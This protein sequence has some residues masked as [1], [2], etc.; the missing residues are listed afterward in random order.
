MRSEGLPRVS[1][2]SAPERELPA[3]AGW[4]FRQ[5]VMRR[6]KGEPIAFGV[7][8][9]TI[10]VCASSVMD[11]SSAR[12]VKQWTSRLGEY[13]QRRLFRI[14]LTNYN[15]RARTIRLHHFV[16]HHRHDRL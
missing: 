12:E 7:P 6:L 5:L 1:F 15:G 13:P 8:V 10:M 9:R 16:I 3:Q 2:R 4:A 11:L 14:C